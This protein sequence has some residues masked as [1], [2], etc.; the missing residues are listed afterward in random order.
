VKHKLER[1]QA[2]KEK[3]AQLP[4]AEFEAAELTTLEAV[5]LL[6]PEVI[7]LYAK[8]MRSR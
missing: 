6:R 5:K 7:S 3:H 1:I 8:A 2:I 4:S